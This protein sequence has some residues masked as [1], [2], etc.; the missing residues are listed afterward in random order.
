MVG[1]RGRGGGNR[2]GDYNVIDYFAILRPL[3]LAG[4]PVSR[5]GEGGGGGE[6]DRVGDCTAID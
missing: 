6:E 5:G 1:G 3:W 4:S 2:V